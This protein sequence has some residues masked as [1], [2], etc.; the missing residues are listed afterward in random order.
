MTYVND[1]FSPLIVGLVTLILTPYD[2]KS[3]IERLSS[4]IQSSI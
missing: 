1:I 4:G 2:I 3:I